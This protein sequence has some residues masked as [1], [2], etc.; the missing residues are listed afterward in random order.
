MSDL[1]HHLKRLGILCLAFGFVMALG[2]GCVSNNGYA[3]RKITTTPIK[4]ATTEIPEAELIDIGIPPTAVPKLTEKQLEKQGTK[5]EIR[6]AESHYIPFHL[7]STLQNSSNWGAVRVIPEEADD[8]DLTLETELVESNG[9]YFVLKVR[10]VDATGR[11]WFKNQYEG[12]GTSPKY[13]NNVQ[14]QKEV[15]QFLYNRVANDLLDFKNR[16]TPEQIQTI[17]TVS[18]MRFA[19][20]FA[21]DAYG[22]FIHENPKTGRVSLYRLPAENDPM[23]NRLMS[24]RER[25]HMYVDTVN[26]YYAGYY[27]NMWDAY[28]NWRKFNLVERLAVREVR[29]DSIMRTATGILL[30]AAA[31]ALEVGDVDNTSTLRNVMVLGGGQVMIS[32]INIS[33]QAE[34]HRTAIGELSESFSGEMAPVTVELEGK[35]YELSGTVNEQYTQWKGILRKI[36]LEETGFD[37]DLSAEEETDNETESE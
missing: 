2:T 33:K 19:A 21:P 7:K 14:G 30:I 18:Q 31:I 5:E 28:Q 23:L 24:I 16:L 29:R 6:K 10:A 25:E 15:Y 8:M 4:T 20:E 11:V 9:E 37:P 13:E 26:E 3:T 12:T 17:R 34:M 1:L 36:Y 27:N 35:K 32:G 22:E